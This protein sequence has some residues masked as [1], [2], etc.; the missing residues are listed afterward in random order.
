[1]FEA[2]HKR[3][4]K[5]EQGVESGLSPYDAAIAAGYSARYARN[6]AAAGA[7]SVDALI[8]HGW[9]QIHNKKNSDR[10]RQ[11]Y[12]E[13]LGEYYGLWGTGRKKPHSDDGGEPKAEGFH[14]RGVPR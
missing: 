2:D 14:I 10:I 9:A 5:F 8:E 7:L 4:A 11:R 3:R 6:L 13:R 1:M 12:W